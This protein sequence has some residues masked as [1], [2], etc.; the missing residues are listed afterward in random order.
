MS[1]VQGLLGRYYALMT[2]FLVDRTFQRLVFSYNIGKAPL[3]IEI[4]RK[5]EGS[6]V[7]LNF[8]KKA[9]V[10]PYRGTGRYC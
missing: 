8:G 7:N 4:I 1:A 5:Q 2:M 9:F 10:I 6:T 3:E